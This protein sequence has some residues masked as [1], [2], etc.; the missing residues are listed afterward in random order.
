MNIAGA[1]DVITFEHG[2][3]VISAQTAQ[4]CALEFGHSTADE[5]GLYA[6]HGFLHLNGY[7]D[8][9]ERERARMHEIQ[10]KI[11]RQALP[12]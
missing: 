2:E 10:D 3:I 4:K 6:V 9:T 5:I 7:L 8:A 1:T 11:W 12:V